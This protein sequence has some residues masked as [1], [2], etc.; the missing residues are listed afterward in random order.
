[1]S[2][3]RSSYDWE[4]AI[5]GILVFAR[6]LTFAD[7]CAFA[8]IQKDATL[9]SESS[10]ITPKLIDGQPIDQIDGGAVRSNNLFHSFEHFSISAG[11]TA[12]FNNAINIQNIISR[13]T[14]NSIS[15][16]DGILKANGTA[17]V[18]LINPNG[19]IFG[20]NASLNIGGSFVAST[21]S[22]L[23]FADGTK[24]SATSPQTTPL[25][26]VSVPIGL[27][28][29]ATA[30]PIRN[31]SQ[32]SP[33]NAINILGEG[34][35]LQV[36]HNKTLALIGGDITLEGGNLTAKGGRIELGSVAGNSLVSLN[37]TNQGWA[38]GYENVQNFQ[39]IELTQ[40]TGMPS[41]VDT[42][43]KGGG[44][45]HLQGKDVLVTD[46]S[47]ILAIT[48]GAQPGGNLTVNASQ[49]VEFGR[50]ALLS[51]GTFN[52]GNSGDIN[53]TTR[54]LIVKDGAQ[55][56]MFNVSSGLAGQLTINASDSVD[57][58]AGIPVSPFPDGSDL[59]SSGLFSATYG[60]QNAGSIT[61]NTGKLR[62]EGGA[63]ISTSSEGILYRFSNQFIP[64]TGNGG[65]L[66]VNASE[67]VELIGTSANGS[68]L[69]SLF[70]GTQGTGD[71]GN[72]TLT[73]GRLTIKDG[74][75]ITV[76]SEARK[77]VNYQGGVPNLGL[78]GELNISARSILLDKGKLT[79]NS[80]SGKGGNIAAQVRDLLLMRRHSQISTN[81]GGDKSG[82][83]ITI[84]SPNGFLV[85][86]S[87]ENSD[88]T[89][90][91][92][93]G[94][95]GK[96][97]ITAKNIFG[98]VP[99]TRAEVE[100]LDPKDINPDNLSTSDIT[101]FSQQNPSLTGT[102]Q[103]NSPDAD[104]SKGLAELPV[105]LVDAS[106]QIVAGCSSGGKIGRSS[107]ITT[108]RGGIAADP[109]QPLIADDAVLADW[110][111]LSPESQNF[112]DGIQKRVVVQAHGNTEKKPQK[113]NS[114]NEPTQIVEA[115]GWI[116]DADG[117]VVLVA[118]VPTATPHNP[119][120]TATSCTAN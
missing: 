96:I 8:Q 77:N 15:N 46:G 92:F 59:V 81:A 112:A 91:A 67:S 90:N 27:Q 23:N 40:Q 86:T 33:N 38:L 94:T 73:T 101:A 99:R 50:A 72:L 21:A 68:K 48:L 95:G 31:Q 74:A 39:N 43:G 16:I 60:A 13:V 10:I 41:T 53:I 119:L 118:Q 9:G 14:G 7:S 97:T 109:T 2:Q 105:N 114:V 83:N 54:E 42:S 36:Q 110:I 45:I 52:T 111:A 28:F 37:S 107:F 19:I 25:L 12:Y 84:N 98:F 11:T 93:S 80:E 6:V 29:G 51:T 70:S 82:G 4:L 65:N 85:A 62:V 17:N 100:R 64:A 1:M 71:G 26:T 88:I 35:G 89:A 69:S 76:S 117:N 87:F 78:A 108:G 44:N 75:A 120:L 106:Q 47:H 55:V 30:A 57:I 56:L 113:V 5:V 20:P 66:T 61:I 34:V 3:N 49:S 104:P 32:A 22:S 79:S 116:R 18:F 102:I 24:F 58:I 103:I 63:R 115:Q